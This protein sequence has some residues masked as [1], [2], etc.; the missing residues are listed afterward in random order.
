MNRGEGP[1]PDMASAEQ[2]KALILSHAEG[3]ETRFYRVALQVAAHHARLGHEAVA[4]ELRE[5]VGTAQ[6]RS[7]TPSRK[8]IPIAR[9]SGALEELLKAS[10]PNAR[11]N[12]LIM[13][14]QSLL[15]LQR[16]LKEHRRSSELIKHG[17]RPR[18]KLLFFGP[19]GTGKTATAHALA[20][21]L[22]LPLFVVRFEGL[23]TRYMGETAAKLSLIF[24][25]MN[26]TCGVY[27]FDEFD[28]I[29]SQRSS[30]NDVG[31]I[32]RV[33]NSFLQFI[34][35]DESQSLLIA[36]TNHG[37]MLDKA[38]FRRFDDV[39]SYE[40][41][42]LEQLTETLKRCLEPFGATDLDWPNLAHEAQGLSY[43]DVI[44]A[45]EDTAK[46]MILEDRETLSSDT[47]LQTLQMRKHS[48]REFGK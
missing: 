35:E 37:E 9:P 36:A 46:D 45:C 32:R 27:F 17:L 6:K 22:Q 4:K 44:R 20:G 40:L 39:I 15:S 3:N 8:P 29:G 2:L 23:I 30:K 12:D 11:L 25:A 18:R 41:P 21:E 47:L 33:L 16:I 38:L 24:Q 13:P 26:D 19:P 28:A 42:S 7:Q 14:N 31:E 34:E 1:G 5:A 10:Y 43:A 48:Q